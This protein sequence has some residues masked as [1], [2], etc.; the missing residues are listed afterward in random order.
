MKIYKKTDITQQTT[1]RINKT[2]RSFSAVI[3]LT[4]L[5]FAVG[6]QIPSV[7]S[8]GEAPSAKESQPD[9][10]WSVGA[11]ITL[12]NQVCA[13]AGSG[14]LLPSCS[15]GV[16]LAVERKIGSQLSVMGLL[17]ANFGTFD[18]SDTSNTTATTPNIDSM[19][20]AVVSV[21]PHWIFNPRDKV[22]IGGYVLVNGAYSQVDQNDTVLRGSTG[23]SSLSQ[24]LTAAGTANYSQLVQ[25]TSYRLGVL[26]G[27]TVETSLTETIALRIGLDIV[28]AN[29]TVTTHDY[30][31]VADSSKSSDTRT[32][33]NAGLSLDPSIALRMSF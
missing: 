30:I 2:Y 9:K 11:G 19:V 14:F 16:G 21:G 23:T 20:S 25:S 8:A 17:S 26:S 6:A 28:S 32:A 4:G 22:R 24:G 5:I 7:A 33:V 18:D 31:S 27:L 1:P 3:A 13:P 29:Y 12:G 10:M 15:P